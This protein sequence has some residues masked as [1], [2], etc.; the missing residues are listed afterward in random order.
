MRSTIRSLVTQIAP[1]DL[2]EQADCNETLA[3]IDS[4]A[5]LFRT[6]KPATPSMHL[7][8]YIVVYDPATA[9]ILLVDH[10]NAQLWLPCGG[11]VEPDEHPASTVSREIY[12]ELGIEA[13]FYWP[14]PCFI[15]V[16]ETVGLTAGHID[17]SLW[18]VVQADSQ[19][20]LHYDQAEFAQI[21]WFALADV[22]LERSDPQLGRF[23]GKFQQLL[24]REDRRL[25]AVR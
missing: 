24:N 20:A 14:E 3:W 8:S 10:R 9:Q 11:H 1:L 19:Q 5:P 7:V 13:Q 15:T 16:T 2:R 4:D 22:P 21:R 23:L 12:E 18:Y 17:V 25:L 6:A